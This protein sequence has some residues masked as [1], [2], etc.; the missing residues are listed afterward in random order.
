MKKILMIAY[1]YPPV[2]GGGVQRT[3]KFAKYLPEFG[4]KPVILTVHD[5]YDYYSDAALVKDVHPCVSVYRSRSIEPMKW[6]RKRLKIKPDVEG[7]SDKRPFLRPVRIK[8]R[9]WLLRLKEILFIPDTEIGWLPFAVV[10]GLYAVKK[11]K[12]N[13]LYST[14]TPYTDHLIALFLKKCTRRPWIAD[15]RDP[16]SLNLHV[17]HF[18]WREALDR[19]FEKCVLKN[20]DCTI[21][22]TE[23]MTRDFQ[24]IYPYARY[25][26]ITNGYDEEDFTAIPVQKENRRPFTITYT[27]I[28]YKERSPRNFLT[29]LS[30][31]VKE[32]PQVARNWRILFVGQMDN[33]GETENADFLASLNLGKWVRHIPYVSHR[34]SIRYALMSD[35][36]L[37]IIDEGFGSHGIMTG[38]LFEYM[39]CRKPIL[40]LVPPGGAAAQLIRE[41]HSG[42][43]VH[44]DAAD[45]MEKA[46]YM[47]YDQ[48]QKRT[49]DKSMGQQ[50]ITRYS[51]YA[52]TRT[53]AG[54][55]DSIVSRPIHS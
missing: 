28:L 25:V 11:E 16:W 40:A 7:R 47:L 50:D 32:N 54:E 22:V 55:C 52:L 27:G 34:E 10:K 37:L 30:K 23:P 38:K 19:L 6:I 43:I 9:Q 12:I 33:P 14:S 2:A 48:T 36:L 31:I 39:R 35:V 53:L 46:L 3:V 13:L 51:R 15:F 44:P 20:A 45:E 49:P 41:T 21:A 42:L 24:R 5:G 4:W 1:F 18:R 26:T 17:R 29:V 8:K